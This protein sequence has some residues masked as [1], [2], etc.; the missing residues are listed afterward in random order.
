MFKRNANLLIDALQPHFPDIEY[1]KNENK[2]RRQSFEIVLQTEDETIEIW[3]GIKKTP[4]REKFPDH[5][6]IIEQLKKYLC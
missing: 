5:S 2:P 6:M 3:T 4:R 1:V